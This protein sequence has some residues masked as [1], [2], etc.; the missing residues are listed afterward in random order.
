VHCVRLSAGHLEGVGLRQRQLSSLWA[1]SCSG[2]KI[3]GAEGRQGW[4]LLVFERRYV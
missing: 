2:L 1:R 3:W 4:V